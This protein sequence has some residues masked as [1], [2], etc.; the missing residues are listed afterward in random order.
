MGEAVTFKGN[1]HDV[2]GY[3]ARPKSGNGPG[4]V[5]IQEWW[6]LVSHIETVADR[7]AAEGF[8]AL[9]PDLYHGAKTTE[10]D[11]AGRL[12]Q[13]LAVPR[14]AKDMSGAVSFL[15][16]HE[17]HAGDAVGTVGFCM[18]GWL[19]LVLATERPEVRAAVT[20]YGLLVKPQP[21]F[22]KLRGA[23]LGH[24]AENDDMANADAVR[25]LD[26]KLTELGTEHTFH[27]YPGTTH[28]FFNDTRPEVYKKDAA[29][30]AWRRTIEFL[31]TRLR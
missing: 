26:R 8:L 17:A 30:L 11:E 28:A 19:A 29:E 1:G 22:S 4:V 24:F 6:G 25:Q 2:T 3:L 5:V 21:D 15:L 13:Q 23:V 27:T 14:A 9:A 7:L 31:R 20:F 16:S 10:P 12:L 18:G